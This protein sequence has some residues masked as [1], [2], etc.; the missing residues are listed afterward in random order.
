[1]NGLAARE[2]LHHVDAGGCSNRRIERVLTALKLAVDE[3]RD[4]L[5]QARSLIKDVRLQARIQLESRE[6]SGAS[7]CRLDFARG[8]LHEASE[9]LGKTHKYRHPT[10]IAHAR[11]QVKNRRGPSGLATDRAQN[12]PNISLPSA[13]VSTPRSQGS[14]LGPT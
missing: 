8:S 1:V 13:S 4:M 12:R 7:G 5:A 10:K 9:L 2:C 14:K 11:A 6:Q 3:N